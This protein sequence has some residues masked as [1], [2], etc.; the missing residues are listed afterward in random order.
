[1]PVVLRIA[2]RNLK[3]HRSK[4]LIIGIIIAVGV[5]ILVV[6]NSLM[7][8]AALGIERAFIG[9]YT[10]H[11]F[12][13]P[14]AEG[15]VSLFGVQ[16]VGGIEE[17]PSLPEFSALWDYLESRPQVKGIT[18]QIT[19]FAAIRSE[20]REDTEVMRATVLFGIRPEEYRGLFDNL[21]MVEGEALIPGEP[22]ILLSQGAVEYLEEEMEIDI[23]PGDSL[24]LNGFGTSGFKIR[25]VYLS[26]IFRFKQ[27]NEI[28]DLISY[29]DASTLRAL[30]GMNLG[31]TAEVELTPEET[32][33]LSAEPEDLD[34]L[35]SDEGLFVQEDFS[36]SEEGGDIFSILDT[37]EEEEPET[38]IVSLPPLEPEEGSWEYILIKLK[39]PSSARRFIRSV[40]TWIDEQGIAAQAGGWKAAAGPFSKSAD[41]V[42][43]VFNVAVIM[44]VIVAVI[45]VMNTLVISV[46]ERTG[47]IGTMRA[48]GGQRS[49][50]RKLF[51]MEIMAITLV[52]GLLGIGVGVL[53]LV[54]IRLIGFEA[55]NAFVEIL[56]AGKVLKPVIEP[57]S[58]AAVLGGVI[59]F[60][61]LANL[62][63]LR[64]A[65]RVPPV[66]AMQTE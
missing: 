57:L 39:R 16:S 40:N 26:G 11:V 32:G 43:V 65:L 48:L 19:G 7:D 55:G 22:G 53:A 66:K 35:F 59:F 60:G 14:L 61:I 54:I 30:K 17:T 5:L 31:G 9:N 20:A 1:M 24:L 2:F 21:V 33:L 29:V 15:E 52:F 49:F 28:A 8:T 18:P 50:I 38:E 45:I 25:E 44:V 23:S 6:G 56:F 41:A 37:P 42:R 13:S 51:S 27:D 12:I 4:T 46:V 64:L 10:G 58:L 62:Y 3:Q 47:E 34:T 36:W 63:P